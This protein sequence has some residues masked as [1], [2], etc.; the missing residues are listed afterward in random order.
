VINTR[1]LTP[2]QVVLERKRAGSFAEEL[3]VTKERSMAVVR[4]VCVCMFCA[5]FVRHGC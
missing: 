4:A 1:P 3:R 2:R 5:R